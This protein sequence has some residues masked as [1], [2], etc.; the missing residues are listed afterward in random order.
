[1]FD[2]DDCLAAD[3]FAG[4]FGQPGDRTL[5]D[6]IVTARKPGECQDC[7]E[8]IQPGQRI[9]SR[10]DFFDGMVKSFRWCAKCC[11][12]MA[13]S[14]RDG[15]EAWQARIALRDADANAK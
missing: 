12:A 7:G 13:L 6:K 10:T 5:R 9:R 2:E 15:G 1:M 4:D 14:W 8:T 11:E 3:P